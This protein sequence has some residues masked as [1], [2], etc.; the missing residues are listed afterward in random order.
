M[1]ESIVV[2]LQNL[3]RPNDQEKHNRNSLEFK[4]S[5]VCMRVSCFVKHSVNVKATIECACSDLRMLLQSYRLMYNR[6]PLARR[7]GERETTK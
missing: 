6:G 3:E 2:G 1:K 4:T 5:S 7:K